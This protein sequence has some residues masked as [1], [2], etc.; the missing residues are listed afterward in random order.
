MATTPNCTRMIDFDTL[1]LSDNVRTENCERIPD[2]VASL[3]RNGFKSNHPLV[4]SAKDNGRHLVL[5]GNRR[6]KGLQTLREQSAED[7]KAALPTGKVACVVHKG[8]TEDEEILL[9]I[10]HSKDEDRVP[11][12]EWSEF[13]AIKQLVRAYPGE[14]QT[15]IAEKLGIISS[16]GKN[17]GKPNRSYVQVR[18]N[19]VRLP[20]FVQ[21][22][23][24]K[25]S[26]DGKDA[27]PVRWADV[28]GLYKEYNLEYSAF[29]DGNGPKFQ[30]LWNDK[31]NP[32]P[33][34]EV[35]ADS[36][37]APKVLTPEN[38]VKRSQA[39]S[40]GLVKRIILAATDQ[41]DVDMVALDAQVASA[42]ADSAAL[43][44]IREYLGADDYADLVLK[45]R[46]AREA[47]EMT[48]AEAQL[49]EPAQTK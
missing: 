32:A 16:K 15:E 37:K 4:V 10:D 44:D 6:T 41:G 42:E 47:R 35:S 26:V 29:P 14:S 8:L 23:Y 2:M 11:L 27:T 25:L 13:L 1:Y 46:E 12:D 33:E 3:R 48:A 7:F 17:K 22:E 36:A 43:A 34:P 19:L 28:G 40:S 5:C 38:A 39:A 30:A 45:A 31:L 24:R 9:R 18:V 20:D 21:S 49:E